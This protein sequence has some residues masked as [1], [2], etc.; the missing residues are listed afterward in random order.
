VAK[1]PLSPKNV[2]IFKLLFGEPTH[3]N[4]L[5]AFLPFWICQRVSLLAFFWNK[6]PPGER[7]RRFLIFSIGEARER[8]SLSLRNLSAWF[9]DTLTKLKFF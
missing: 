3:L 1:E 2:F 7:T 6:K 5:K 9:Q 8:N 4:I